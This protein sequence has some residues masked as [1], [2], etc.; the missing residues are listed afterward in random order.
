MSSFKRVIIFILVLSLTSI[1]CKVPSIDLSSIFGPD[2]YEPG[3][4][5]PETDLPY[6]LVL[7]DP[8]T[9]PQPVPTKNETATMGN[10]AV[11]G[12]IEKEITT[13]SASGDDKGLAAIDDE[14]LN[15]IVP[16]VSI[17]KDGRALKR[18]AL[19]YLSVGNLIMITVVD[20]DDDYDP[21]TVTVTLEDLVA[22]IDEKESRATSYGKDMVA[23]VVII[24]KEP[25][26]DQTVFELSVD[27]EQFLETLGDP[28]QICANGEQL[29]QLSAA[30]LGLIFM[31]N[32]I[33]SVD[34]EIVV[35]GATQDVISE[36]SDYLSGFSLED[37]LLY[38]YYFPGEGVVDPLLESYNL[39]PAGFQGYFA[40]VG[41]CHAVPDLVGLPQADAENALNSLPLQYLLTQAPELGADAAGLVA[42]QSPLPYSDSPLFGGGIVT[43]LPENPASDAERVQL[44]I[45]IGLR[46]RTIPNLIG[47]SLADAESALTSLGLYMVVTRSVPCL[48]VAEGQV[49]NQNP[50]PD[51]P[52]EGETED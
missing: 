15:V 19:E 27:V 4:E 33:I 13:A 45:S 51:T 48:N 44:T 41:K 52:F 31:N 26:S 34:E 5:L 21:V 18:A 32:S 39:D 49:S 2:Y 35:I 22:A 28:V 42:G 12:T 38:D 24:L 7:V 14:R 20:E 9:L 46:P 50:L 6:A 36:G 30:S 23:G 16:I 1:S 3:D 8:D 17:D 25:A 10:V 40:P 29:R 43:L 47:M 37:A 11:G